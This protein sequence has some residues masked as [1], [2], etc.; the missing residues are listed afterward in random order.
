MRITK[1]FYIDHVSESYFLKSDGEI[2]P[3]ARVRGDLLNPVGSDEEIPL[4]D[5][6][7]VSLSLP[8]QGMYLPEEDAYVREV[9]LPF[10]LLSDGS[11]RPAGV[12]SGVHVALGNRYVV[13]EVDGVLRVALLALVQD[14]V[15]PTRL[16]AFISSL[17]TG[18]VI[19]LP[20]ETGKQFGTRPLFI[21]ARSTDE[22]TKDYAPMAR[23]LRA[24]EEWLSVQ[25]LPELYSEEAPIVVSVPR[26]ERM[27]FYTLSGEDHLEGLW[28]HQGDGRRP[29]V[30]SEYEGFRPMLVEGTLSDFAFA[31]AVYAWP[32]SDAEGYYEIG[33]QEVAAEFGL[34]VRRMLDIWIEEGVVLPIRERLVAREW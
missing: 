28:V 34:A 21:D 30:F 24:D 33:D 4:S 10:V 12:D 32:D 29:I 25:L 9:Q 5:G 16:E 27:V 22:W 23:V 20:T 14:S 6:Q 15:T 7:F 31:L 19:P 2:I 3:V 17:R 18:E 26:T 8:A 1:D 11:V 13:P